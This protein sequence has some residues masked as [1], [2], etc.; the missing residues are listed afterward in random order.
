MTVVYV[1]PFKELKRLRV[2]GRYFTPIVIVID[3]VFRC[4]FL[5]ES[6]TNKNNNNES[7]NTEK[8]GFRKKRRTLGGRGPQDP[9]PA[10]PDNLRY[11]WQCEGPRDR[12]GPCVGG[13][14]NRW[15][16]SSFYGTVPD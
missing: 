15:D 13:D 3:V 6:F 7:T 14:G 9:G 2:K 5:Y 1:N 8:T 12:G 10:A 16:E 4:M 11:E